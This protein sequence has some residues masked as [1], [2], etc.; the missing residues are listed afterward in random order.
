MKIQGI[1]FDLWDTLV[2]DSKKTREIKKSRYIELLSLYTVSELDVFAAFQHKFPEEAATCGIETKG[3]SVCLRTEILLQKLKQNTNDALYLAQSISDVSLMHLPIIASGVLEML[4]SLVFNYTLTIISNTRW[5]YGDTSR[6]ILAKMGLDSFFKS[7]VFSEEVGWAKPSPRIFLE[8]WY[9][10]GI[11]PTKTVHIGDSLKRDHYGARLTGSMSIISRVINQHSEKEDLEADA[12]CYNYND[13]PILIQY[14]DSRNLPK[15]WQLLASGISVHGTVVTGKVLHFNSD[16]NIPFGCILIF[17]E[18]FSYD[19]DILHF[20]SA[21]IF[22][23]H[24]FGDILPQILK[25]IDITYALVTADKLISLM[26]NQSVLLDGKC[27]KI[28]IQN[29]SNC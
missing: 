24:V 19:I 28:W 18:I 17:K 6:I 2:Y 11:D 27:G 13:L 26:N 8:A 4:N 15:Q 1:S 23:S 5:T 25:H 10:H 12:I 7:T 3:I 21:I 22:E 29:N 16:S 20:A 14:I 9:P